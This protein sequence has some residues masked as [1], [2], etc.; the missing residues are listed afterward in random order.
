MAAKDTDDAKTDDQEP[1]LQLDMSQAAV[2][3]MITEARERGFITYEQLNQVL[4]PEQVSSEQIEDVMS[5]LSEMG[6]NIIEEEEAEDDTQ[7]GSTDVVEASTSREVTV[8]QTETEKL[9]RTDDPVRMYLR[10]MGSVELLSREG[11]IAIAKR[12]EAGRNTMIA[13]L[14]ESPLTFQAITIWRDELLNEDILL[15]DVI[16]L[17]ATFGRSLEEDGVEEP[18]V[19]SLKV[20][21]ASS[22]R[23]Q[24]EARQQGNGKDDSEQ[25][26]LDADGNPIRA[27]DS[28]EDD[29]DEQANMSLAAMEAALKPR[30]LETL[31]RIADNYAMLSDMQDLRMSATL[32]EDG[33][34]SKNEEAAYQK[35]RSEIV[36]LV[37]SLHLH[38]NRIEALI[39]QLY[40]INRKIMSID[41]AMVKLADQARI[42]RRE[43]VD[44]YRGCELD[45]A[46]ME[47]MSQK[48]GRGWQALV[49]RSGEKVDELRT[50][51]AQVGQYVGVDI[52][53][54]R[55]IVSQVQK[56][57]KEARQAKKEMVEANLRLVISIAKKYTN[58]G[59]QFLDLIQ[60]GNIGLMKAV[61]KFEY[62]RGYKF[63]TY[64]TWWIRQAITRSIADQART[65]RIPVHM[66]ETINKLVRTGRQMLH[67]IGREPTPEELA[68]KLQMPLEKVR[69]V[70]KIAKEP[71]SLETP[72]GDE[73][74]SQLGDFIEDKNAVLPLDS[75]IQGNLKETTTRVLASLTPREERVLRMRFGIGMNTDHTLEEVGQQF[76]VTRER[77]RQIEAKALRK[78]KH[79]SRSR[80]LRSFLDQ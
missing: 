42:N 13:G 18:V 30:V 59:L 32:N 31:D 71:I 56:G 65:I 67:E 28:E 41:S 12:I 43:F 64:A 77:I 75:A 19:A 27:D 23:P 20:A 15:R 10:E 70:M 34:F 78:L 52:S 5:M 51:M 66:I 45:P 80:K 3:K 24:G 37:N 63:S 79:P 38:N 47:R 8:A 9:D 69:K 68:E 35:L 22:V 57:E 40:G 2:K 14:C 6:I 39:D 61:D 48:S 1:E 26:E 11:E 29:E 25:P 55:R 7:K 21:P 17:D 53:E 60:E 4:P 76:S 72:I 74:D 49:E 33:S 44:E 16:D 54:F 46:W 62:R 58:R 50:E 73:E 36:E